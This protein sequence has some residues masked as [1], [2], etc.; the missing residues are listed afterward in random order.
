MAVSTD[1]IVGFPGESEQDFEESLEFVRQMNFASGHVFSFSPRAGTPAA[2]YP[3]QVHPTVRK[4]RSARMRA[5]LAESGVAYRQKFV[6]RTVGVLWEAASGLGP[7]GWQMEGLSDQYLH[8]RAIS[9]IN[10]WNRIQNVR[11]M[12][13]EGEWLNGIIEAES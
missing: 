5:V 1:V 9:P 13:L 4:E 12:E 3:G 6:G 7:E 10:A 8:V 11:L 2:A